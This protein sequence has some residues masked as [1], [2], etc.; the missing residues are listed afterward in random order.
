MFMGQKQEHSIHKTEKIVSGERLFF[1]LH[2]GKPSGSVFR[3]NSK[4]GT[5]IQRI[6]QILL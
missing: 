6:F 1:S 3:M 4:R 5:N 2:K